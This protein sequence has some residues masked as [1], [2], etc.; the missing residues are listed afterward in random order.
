MPGQDVDNFA[1]SRRYVKSFAKITK[2]STISLK[3]C[4]FF[5]YKSPWCNSWLG[6]GV[7]VAGRGSDRSKRDIERLVR[8]SVW[9]DS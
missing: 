5:Y 3:A 7:V 2:L 4:V 1:F 6:V 8:F 9:H